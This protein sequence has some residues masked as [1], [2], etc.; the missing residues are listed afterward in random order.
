L[1]VDRADVRVLRDPYTAKPFVMFYVTKRLGGG[2]QNFDA[3]KLLRF[4]VS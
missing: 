4:T 2:I 1:I 3:I